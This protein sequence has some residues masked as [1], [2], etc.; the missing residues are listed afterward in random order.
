MAL[1]PVAAGLSEMVL[2]DPPGHHMEEF[3]LPLAKEDN[4]GG[5]PKP[6]GHM[7]RLPSGYFPAFARA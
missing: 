5:P 4:G 2:L 7:N 1:L 6:S 3:S